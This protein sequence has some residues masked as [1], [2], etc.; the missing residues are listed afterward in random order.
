MKKS[1][2]LCQL[3]EDQ[4]WVLDPNPDNRAYIPCSCAKGWKV[5]G[6]T[7]IPDHYALIQYKNGEAIT[8]CEAPDLESIGDAAI[9]LHVQGEK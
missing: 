7:P 5:S 6:K 2:A 8:V 9:L 4:G 3:C 1:I